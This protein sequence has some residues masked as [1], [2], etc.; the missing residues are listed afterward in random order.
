VFFVA[1]GLAQHL[2]ADAEE[3]VAAL[4]VSAGEFAPQRVV[5][6]VGGAVDV[7]HHVGLAVGLAGLVA[8]DVV[9]RT[10][11]LHAVG[12]NDRLGHT[13]VRNG[14]HQ[15]KQEKDDFHADRKSALSHHATPSCVFLLWG[16]IFRISYFSLVAVGGHVH[17]QTGGQQYNNVD[18]DFHPIYVFP[19]FSS[20][21]QI[22]GRGFC[23]VI[24]TV[25]LYF[26]Q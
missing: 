14:S 15:G 2:L 17:A 16:S 20:N 18:E 26:F 24:E 19:V 12:G 22:Q 25:D 13:D 7:R 1:G 5:G 6:Q 11:A 21:L 9:V 8:Q 3:V 4:Q 23:F 10:G